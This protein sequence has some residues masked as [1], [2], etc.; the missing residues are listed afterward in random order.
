MKQYSSSINRKSNEYLLVFYDHECNF[1]I[2]MINWL[3]KS[4]TYIPFQFVKLASLPNYLTNKTLNNEL[5]YNKE[6]VVIDSQGAIYLNEKAFIMCLFAL[7]KYRHWAI[8]LSKPYLMPLTK[9]A[10]SLLSAHRSSL[11]HLLRLKDKELNTALTT[12]STLD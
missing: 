10:C 1:C 6:L 12:Y 2:N 4:A 3:G 9:Q 5:E 11:T 7:K 8:R